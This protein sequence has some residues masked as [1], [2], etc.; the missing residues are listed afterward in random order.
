MT[1]EKLVE[2]TGQLLRT[3][4]DEGSKSERGGIVLQAENGETYAVRM[5]DEPSFGTSILESLIGSTV[6]TRGVANDTTLIIQDLTV[7]S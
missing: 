7:R 6:T 2:V 4:L 5:R 3:T 1:E